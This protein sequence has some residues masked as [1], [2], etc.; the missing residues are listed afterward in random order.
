VKIKPPLNI[1]RSLVEKIV[2]VLDESFSV[3]EKGFTK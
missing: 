3:V 1:E 2:D